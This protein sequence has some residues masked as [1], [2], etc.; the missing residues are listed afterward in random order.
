MTGVAFAVLLA[1]DVVWLWGIFRL[2][3]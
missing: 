3:R 1:V 2:R